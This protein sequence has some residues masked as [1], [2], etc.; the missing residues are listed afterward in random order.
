M[1]CSRD[2][3]GP[4]GCQYHINAH[5]VRVGWDKI[6]DLLVE[7]N[8]GDEEVGA[9]GLG[10]SQK[11]VVEAASAAQTGTVQVECNSRH[12]HDIE[13]GESQRK[14]IGTRLQNAVASGGAI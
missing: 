10:A 4:R 1:S 2:L 9:S 12:E 8:P 13:L 14:K 5:I 7:A 3:H 6:H 11:P